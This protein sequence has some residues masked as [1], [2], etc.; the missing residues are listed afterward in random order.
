MQSSNDEH[1]F[2]SIS[3]L[4]EGEMFEDGADPV[5]FMI[6]MVFKKLKSFAWV[7]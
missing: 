3:H 1:P 7:L 5:E 6:G 2:N 4:F